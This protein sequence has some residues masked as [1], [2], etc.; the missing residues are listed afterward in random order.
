MELQGAHE[1]G[2]A[3]GRESR[4]GSWR[5]LGRRLGLVAASAYVL[6]FYSEYVFLNAPAFTL[7]AGVVAA[8]AQLPL[9]LVEMTLWYLL[10]A[11]ALLIA[12]ERYRVRGLWGLMLA[13]ALYGIVV[14]GVVVT[15]MY[16]ALPWSL[17]WTALSW[18]VLID[19]WLGWWLTRCVLQR[20]RWQ[21]SAA[22]AVGLGLFWGLWATWAAGSEPLMAPRAFAVFAVLTSLLWV[23]AN[24][25]FDWVGRE[26]FETTRVERGM[27]WMAGI[28]L[29]VIWSIQLP[30]I[31]PVLVLMVGLTLLGLWRG[32]RREDP[33][34]TLLSAF[35]GRRVGWQVG[36]L[37]LTPVV[38][39]LTYPLH[40]QTDI[41]VWL[42][43]ELPVAFM[44]VGFV[45]YVVAWMRVGRT[46]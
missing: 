27:V 17:S 16:E 10:P 41:G 34:P 8:S 25:V 36:W 5:A 18:H 7:A 24:A 3:V 46:G 14:E 32:R 43:S 31:P 35:Q 13:G 26:S 23:A 38:A 45:V 11:Y 42:V 29:A 15:Q 9:A 12:L 22:Y 33:R 28:V 40:V 6:A 2:G 30:F 1:V 20:R 21:W 44:G 37:L 19:V 39:A 4:S